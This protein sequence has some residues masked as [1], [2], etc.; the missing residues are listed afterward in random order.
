M[1][2]KWKHSLV[3]KIAAFVLC[4]AMA[5]MGAGAIFAGTYLWSESINGRYNPSGLPDDMM[6][7]VFYAMSRDDAYRITTATID[8]DTMMAQVF[9]QNTNFGISIKK[10]SG[11]SLGA[12]NVAL[13]TKFFYTY[14]H[15]YDTEFGDVDYTVTVY[16]NDNFPFQDKYSTVYSLV[17]SLYNH[18]YALIGVGLVCVAATL[19]CF[20]FL[21]SAAGHKKGVEGIT[22]GY[23]ARKVPFDLFTVLF[24]V[25]EVCLINLGIEVSYYGTAAWLASWI[26]TILLGVIGMI[27]GLLYCMNVAVRVK[28]GSWRK[29]TLI[30]KAASGLHSSCKKPMRRMADVF[31]NI[32]LIW[33]TAIFCLV[34]A[35]F[36][37][38]AVALPGGFGLWVLGMFILLPVVLYIA[39]MLRRLQ[40]GSQALARGDLNYQ[41]NTTDLVWDFK[42][43]AE[44]LNQIAAGMTQAVEERL[45]SERFKTELITN[46]SHD[47]KTPLTSIINYA[48]LIGKEECD[49]KTIKDYAAV[50]LRQSERLKKLI[51]DLV[52]ASKASSG[53]LDMT[54]APCELGV[55]LAQTMGEYGQKMEERKLLLVVKQPDEAVWIMADGRHL[56]RVFDNLMNNICKYALS[57]TRVYLVLERRHG[58]VSIAFKNTSADPLDVPP[59]ELLARFVRGDRS[60]HSEGNGLGLAIAQSLTEQ[61]GGRLSLSVE[62]DL[63]KV[64]LSFA[65]LPE[66]GI[67]LPEK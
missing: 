51:E 28:V 2:T 19:A 39:L 11:E 25:L 53:A 44:S 7:E 10:S 20:V 38:L 41:I 52:E 48:D 67:V 8:G 58:E 4:L 47:I 15:S 36:S 21:L 54:L 30:Y 16:I 60:R 62:A 31:R 27:I 45:K 3:A 49:N 43:A 33:R 64:T 18:R 12:Y 13:G 35:F 26:P 9:C 22:A 24:L 5:M 6:N 50:L 55:L 29:N 46:V 40:A 61:Q 17:T 42:T 56:W 65:A 34:F 23:V 57:G 32:P 66:Q 37:F 14:S 59:E 1:I 63:F